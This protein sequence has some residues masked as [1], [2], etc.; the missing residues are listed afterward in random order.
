MGRL[1]FRAL[2]WSFLLLLFGFAVS[3][4]ARQSPETETCPPPGESAGVAETHL[5]FVTTRNLRCDHRRPIRFGELRG[6][7]SFGRFEGAQTAADRRVTPVL[8]TPAAWLAELRSD[9]AGNGGRVLIYVHGYLNSFDEALDRMRLIR[10]LTGVTA[11]MLLFSW[12]SEDC[13]L[14]YTRDEENALWTQPQFDEVLDTL[15]HDSA[16]TEIVLVAHSMGN[17]ILLRGIGTADA[18]MAALSRQKLRTVVLASPDIDRAMFRRDYLSVVDQPDR[19]TVIYASQHDQALGL[20]RRLHGY[21]RA[22]QTVCT[23]TD[24]VRDR[25][26]VCPV[27]LRPGGNVLLVDTSPVHRGNGHRDFVESPAAAMDFCRVLRGDANPPG[28]EPVADHPNVVLLT[29]GALTPADCPR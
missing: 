22:G 14:C 5:Y 26:A 2:R 7:T 23:K 11:P 18:S 21:P 1:V 17:R 13:A 27:A 6:S 20:S 28:R 9:A 15:L 12:P 10:R 4:Q 3:A 29:N 25:R 16:I 19:S 8:R 24:G